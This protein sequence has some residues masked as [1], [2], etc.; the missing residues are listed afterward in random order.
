MVEK[1]N[2][3]PF[4]KNDLDEASYYVKS[5][6]GQETVD[7]IN[8]ESR[9][10]F[11]GKSFGDLS[12]SLRETDI[13]SYAYFLKDVKYQEKFEKDKIQFLGG[14]IEG[15][16]AKNLNQKKTIKILK[17]KDDNK[18]IVKISLK[19]KADELILAK[20]YEMDDPGIVVNE[21]NKN[22][23]DDLDSLENEDWFMVPEI[24]LDYHREYEELINEY[25]ANKG[26]KDY[27]ISQMFENIKFDMDEEGAR[28]ENEAVISMD[29]GSVALP[30]KN[31]KK[32]VFDKPYW[33]MMK[34][35]D[36]INPYFILGINNNELMKKVK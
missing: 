24:H 25:L 21:I 32:I 22:N 33:V 31:F 12:I 6:Y 26:F 4:S 15:F 16:K 3:S 35:S 23:S 11:P 8:K 36:S 27:Y 29:I 13:I 5:G 28:V 10:K 7:Q 20:G 18:F 34:R 9:E 1:L 2:S 17:Y 19:D 30:E 14:N